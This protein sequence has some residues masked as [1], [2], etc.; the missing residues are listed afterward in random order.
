MQFVTST[1]SYMFRHQSAIPKESTK[2]KEHVTN[3]PIQVLIA[4][5][6]I[7]NYYYY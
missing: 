2:T 3:T 6:L 1:N 5:T 4:L 7:I